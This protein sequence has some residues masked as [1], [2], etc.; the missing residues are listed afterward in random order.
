MV[1]VIRDA[2]ISLVEEV[3]SEW[4]KGG[5]PHIS[6]RGCIIISKSGD[7]TLE[8]KVVPN[9]SE[10]D[11]YKRLKQMDYIPS[12]CLNYE[13]GKSSHI[14]PTVHPSNIFCIP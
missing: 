3:E 10:I 9:P 12:V 7:L 1:I 11:R 13:N 14:L 6:A 5:F 4:L 2:R 8:R